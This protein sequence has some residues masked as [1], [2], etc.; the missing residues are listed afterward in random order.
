[1]E[2]Q[3][4]VPRNKRVP[5]KRVGLASLR[6]FI[7]DAVCFFYLAASSVQTEE[8]GGE[9][10][11]AAEEGAGDE[12]AEARAVAEGAHLGACLEEGGE[13]GG[14]ERDAAGEGGLE[15]V[16]DAVEGFGSG[17]AGGSCREGEEEGSGW[18]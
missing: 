15:V 9:G 2:A 17:E 11:T 7:E 4:G 6:H 13:E 18:R 3:L 10:G 16:E 1:M 8:L 14:V 12:E 5:R